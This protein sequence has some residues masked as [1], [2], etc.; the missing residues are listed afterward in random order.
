VGQPTIQAAL[1]QAPAARKPASALTR[2]DFHVTQ[3]WV[4]SWVTSL[5]FGK[6]KGQLGVP[7]WPIFLEMCG[8]A[9]RNRTDDLLNAMNGCLCDNTPGSNN[10]FNAMSP[11]TRQNAAKS[12]EKR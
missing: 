5:E 4:T 2:W 3:G 1:I 8:G 9:G 7:N 6:K 10:F 11:I 12:A